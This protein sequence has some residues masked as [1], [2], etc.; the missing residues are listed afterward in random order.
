MREPRWRVVKTGA[1]CDSSR[2][3]CFACEG[4]KGLPSRQ[5][6]CRSEAGMRGHRHLRRPFLH[7]AIARVSRVLGTSS[8]RRG[9]CRGQA[10]SL[11]KLPKLLLNISYL[12]GRAHSG[13]GGQGQAL[14]NQDT[15]SLLGGLHSKTLSMSI[16]SC[17]CAPCILYIH[18]AYGALLQQGV[19]AIY[20]AIMWAYPKGLIYSG[21]SSAGSCLG[22]MLKPLICVSVHSP[23]R[24]Y[25]LPLQGSPPSLMYADGSLRCQ[26]GLSRCGYVALVRDECSSD[27]RC[28]EAHAAQLPVVLAEV[29]ELHAHGP[30]KSRC[31]DESHR[32]RAALCK[33]CSD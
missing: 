20:S 13:E 26:T 21:P 18:A 3:G 14:C 30:D 5:Q 32:P 9:P 28:G 29:Q 15:S 12:R 2:L 16:A 24:C 7:G 10:G 1:R 19:Q 27:G 17:A 33:C 22:R 4:R 11:E 25:S 31:S 6:R 23:A 8:M